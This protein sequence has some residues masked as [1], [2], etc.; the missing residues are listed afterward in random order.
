MSTKFYFV[1]GS[2]AGE[3]LQQ[4][5]IPFLA[6]ELAG[7]SGFFF[8][9]ESKERA[10]TAFGW[11]VENGPGFKELPTCEW[12]VSE[13]RP[14]APAA[15]TE[16]PVIE[17]NFHSEPSDAW[18]YYLSLVSNWC[19]GHSL[20]W[21][22]V[23]HYYH[24]CHKLY[25]NGFTH[26]CFGGQSDYRVKTW[27][28]DRDVFFQRGHLWIGELGPEHQHCQDLVPRILDEF[29]PRIIDR[30]NNFGI[31]S[32][33][34][35]GAQRLTAQKQQAASD[36]ENATQRVRDLQELLT[37]AIRRELQLMSEA[38]GLSLCESSARQTL[39]QQINQIKSRSF[40]HFVH[41]DQRKKILS[42]FIERIAIAVEGT[43]Y[44]LGEFQLD[45]YTDGRDNGVRIYNLTRKGPCLWDRGPSNHP[46]V[47]GYGRPCLGNI[48][49]IVPRYIAEQEYAA[50]VDLLYNYL[51]NVNPGDS[52]GRTIASWPCFITQ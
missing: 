3:T 14:S 21:P 51:S 40:V 30:N 15:E 16:I 20:P 17:I 13:I 11:N 19:Q 29:V 24:L 34:D 45:I 33:V 47:D 9:A 18:R 23:I 50:L 27:V 44:D 31:D 46:H 6:G 49:N 5:R 12:S 22:V 26:L 41:F 52:W 36:I 28:C 35:N 1:R 48:K 43:T 38:D 37:S 2:N 7:A 4:N 25:A 39:S 10:L 32:F 42:V 8:P